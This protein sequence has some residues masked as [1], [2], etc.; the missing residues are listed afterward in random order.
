MNMARLALTY[1]CMGLLLTG[2]ASAS[3]QSLRGA[4]T[5]EGARSSLD[6]QKCREYGYQRGTDA[7]ANCRLK[8]EDIRASDGA[9]SEVDRVRPAVSE[10]ATVAGD[11]KVYEASECIGPVIMGEC[12]GSILPNKAYHPTCHGEWLNGQCT[13]PMF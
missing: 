13:G 11:R 9:T 6:D 2:C 10:P 12:K 8:L 7:Y 4:F 3:R 1:L 5:S